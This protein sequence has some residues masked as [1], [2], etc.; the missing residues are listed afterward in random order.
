VGPDLTGMAVHPKT[1][2]LTHILDP[3]RNVE[4]NYRVYTVVTDD[5]RVLNGLLAAET[6]TSIELIDAEAKRHHVLRENIDEL[7]AS[8]K[9]LMPEGFEKQVP[10]DDIVNLLEFLTQ[11]GKY[12]PLDLRRAATA[13][14]TRGMFYSEDAG[15]ERLVFSDWSPKTFEGVPFALIDPQGDRVRN[16]IMLY[17]PTGKFPPTMPKSVELACNAP[18]KAIHFLSGVS[19]WGAQGEL[20]NGSVSMIVRL[21]YTDGQTEDHPLRNGEYF[22]DYI[23]HFDVPKSKLAFMLRSQ[24]LRYFAIAPGRSAPI[25][26]IELVKGPDHTAPVVMA[27]TV[28]GP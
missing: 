1:E 10:S 24:Q 15:A 14:S 19:G 16:A 13:V 2:L 6:K 7:A 25:A 11:R 20:E 5:G 12:L 27:V 17:G 3:S 8:T 21:Q 22:A 28:E 18:A 26:R 23:G 9:S 4:G